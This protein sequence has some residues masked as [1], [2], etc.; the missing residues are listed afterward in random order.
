MER[1]G[2]G[3]RKIVEAYEGEAVYK[4]ELKPVFR[5]SESS[6]RTLLRNL[7]YDTQNDTQNDIQNDTQNDTQNK[8]KRIKPDERRKKIV[9]IMRNN[10]EVTS[11]E[12][13]ELFSVSLITIKRDLKK[14]TE[15]EI[16]EY[17]G[18]AKDG[19]WNVKN[20]K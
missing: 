13:S 18:S 2:S 4:E 7:N 17:I 15:E 9:A 20:I 5:S 6:F 10:S 8:G 19:Y 11:L 14:L 3:L 16:I 12:L 1:R